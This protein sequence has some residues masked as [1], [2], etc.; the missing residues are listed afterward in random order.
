V[1]TTLT[2]S[3]VT[4]KVDTH[5]K[6]SAKWVGEP[7][8][9]SPGRSTARLVALPEMS[10][11][12][13]GLVHGGFTFGLADYAAMLAVNDPNVVLGATEVKFLAPVKVGDVMLAKAEVQQ[14]AGKKRLVHCIVETD[15]KIFE[16][17][18]T[19]YVLEKHVLDV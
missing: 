18:F 16:G 13:R 1:S 8:E 4:L 7:V 5:Q 15:R 19:C 10:V 3:L 6:I 12:E 14:A 9:L 11:D 17:V 2:S